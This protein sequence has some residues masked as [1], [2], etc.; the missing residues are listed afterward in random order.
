M[1]SVAT[2]AP[3]V[4]VR[5]RPKESVCPP[6]QEFIRVRGGR[7]MPIHTRGLKGDCR[8]TACNQ[9]RAWT[10]ARK[11]KHCADLRARW[12]SPEG[13]VWRERLRHR[14][15]LATTWTAEQHDAL[16]E[17][18]GTMD[19]QAIADT[20]NRRFGT[21][22]TFGSV[23]GQLHKLGI[24]R[25]DGRP[26]SA[27]E[28]ARALG[29]SPDTVRRW[30]REGLLVGTPWRLT[31]WRKRGAMTQLFTDAQ[32][33]AFVRAHL[34]LLRIGRI[35][36][37]KLRQVAETLSRGR[38]LYSPREAAAEVGV[39][40]DTLR[41]WLRPGLV[42]GARRLDNGRWRIPASALPRLREMAAVLAAGGRNH[43]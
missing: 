38:R 20:L 21:R 40:E 3:T 25:W 43:A 12:A 37:P 42:P 33:E 5:A 23:Q 32:L 31:G 39:R 34:D 35:R 17:L 13:D 26:R 7:L 1:G 4:S 11:R 41:T 2:A 24:S 29:T 27:P 8:C 28:V 19:L 18:A 15:P 22:R 14:A 9:R 36:D 10:P 16:R 6:G 30:I